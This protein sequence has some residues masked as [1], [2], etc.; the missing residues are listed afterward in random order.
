MNISNIFLILILTLI[1]VFIIKSKLIKSNL[2]LL[3]EYTNKKKSKYSFYLVYYLFAL[4]L[5]PGLLIVKGEN[6]LAIII[7]IINVIFIRKILDMLANNTYE[8]FVEISEYV[9]LLIREL[10]INN[11]LTTI[12]YRINN[13]FNGV[14]IK[15]K[16]IKLHQNSIKVGE[17]NA[18]EKELYATSNMWLYCIIYNLRSYIVDGKKDKVLD[19][20]DDIADIL[21]GQITTTQENKQ[22]NNPII[23]SN[24]IIL[25]ISVL[26]FILNLAINPYANDYFFS[27]IAGK[28]SLILA[29]IIVY[30]II[31]I[32]LKMSKGGLK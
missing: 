5:T 24:Y 13:T 23:L 2:L 31:V 28:V 12:F 10:S 9:T 30:V 29:N 25:A 8:L 19:S 4:L 26:S 3:K 1:F 32:N 14:I 7:F 6:I 21:D 27:S 17:I 15:E 18:L 20:L 16:F 11:N 22:K